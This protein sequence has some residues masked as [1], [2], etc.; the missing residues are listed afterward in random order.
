MHR[1]AVH[2]IRSYHLI[3]IIT[4]SL[5]LFF[6][7]FFRAAPAAYG[8]SQARDQIRAIAPAYTKATATPD[9]SLICNLH[10]SSWPCRIFNPLSEAKIEPALSWILV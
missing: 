4:G 3:Y 6:F 7:F 8:S 1:E 9:L 2:H 5:Y 10:H